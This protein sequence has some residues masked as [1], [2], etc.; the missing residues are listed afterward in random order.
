MNLSDRPQRSHLNVNMLA[1]SL[2]TSATASSITAPQ[3][4][5]VGS[6]PVANGYSRKSGSCGM[7]AY[8]GSRSNKHGQDGGLSGSPHFS[9]KR[10]TVIRGSP[11]N[12][13]RWQ[14]S[15]LAPW[16]A[17]LVAPWEINLC[18]PLR[19]GGPG[20]CPAFGAAL[21]SRPLMPVLEFIH[22]RSVPVPQLRC[23]ISGRAR[24]GGT[25]A[26]VSSAGG[27]RR[28]RQSAAQS[29]RKVCAEIPPGSQPTIQGRLQSLA[30]ER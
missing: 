10:R 16:D 9:V 13:S 2:C 12:I 18:S 19:L 28:M 6:A 14:A 4:G 29:R 17:P 27:L 22:A 21:R 15:T 7:A 24:R 5:Q 30:A 3:R 8:S 25:D 23:R 26:Q 11:R 1:P 20:V